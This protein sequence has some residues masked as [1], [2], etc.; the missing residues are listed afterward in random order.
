MT[1]TSP[2]PLA[3][4]PRGRPGANSQRLL[5]T[6][7]A[8]YRFTAGGC[9]PSTAIVRLLG[10]FG[11]SESA[12]RVALS[13]LARRGL[14][15]QERRGRQSF[16]SVNEENLAGRDKRLR[17]YLDF[18]GD[19]E[20]WDG[21]WTVV[22]FSVSEDRRSL[23]PRLRTG[24]DRLKFAPMTDAVWVQARDHR[25]GVAALGAE[26]DV[27]LAVMRA[28]FH[29]LDHDAM[30]PVDAF[31]LVAA[32]ERYTQFL[33]SFEHLVHRAH[34]GDIAPA[35][36]LIVRTTVLAAWR[37]IALQDADLPHE[38]LPTDWPQP[39]ARDVFTEL[40]TTMGA[41]GL[42]RMRELVAEF[43]PAAAAQLDYYRPAIASRSTH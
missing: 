30:D 13:R 10:E 23:R 40:W 6:L 36:A 32:R 38:V 8:D 33:N 25:D 20:P 19:R 16:Y 4:I 1:T 43:D 5:A 42:I 24:L 2:T 14:L 15:V 18:G 41:L 3:E 31:D 39:R 26:L 29:D 28:T 9:F 17:L 21:L 34:A 27:R 12:A 35:E 7:V 11:I 37:D 22:V